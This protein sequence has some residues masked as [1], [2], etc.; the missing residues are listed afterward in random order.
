MDYFRIILAVNFISFL[1]KYLK[2]H[3]PESKW[4]QNL[5]YGLGTAIAFLIIKISFPGSKLL[6]EWLSDILLLGL[7]Y[8]NL[9]EKDFEKVKGIA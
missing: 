7:I 4:D 9:T 3:H 8:L 1:R 2:S 6:L 5:K